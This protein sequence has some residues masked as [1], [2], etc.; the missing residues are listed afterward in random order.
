MA[1]LLVL[2][3]ST[4]YRAR[5]VIRAARRL[6]VDLVVATDHEQVL[7][8]QT[9]DATLTIPFNDPVSAWERVEELHG[10]RP[11]DAVVGLDDE[12]ILAAAALAQAL[13]VPANSPDAIAATRSKL[14]MRTLLAAAG[15]RSPEFRA[16]PLTDLAGAAAQQDFP[17]VL[18]PT[19]LSGSRGV[20]RADSVDEFV[21]AGRRIAA[22]LAEI[23]VYQG[24][25]DSHL[26]MVESYLEGTEVA[27]DGLLANGNFQPIAFFDK[28]D[29]LTGPYFEETLYVTPSRHPPATLAAVQEEIQLAVLAL[30]LEHG[31]VHAEL[32][33]HRGTPTL[34]EIAARPIGG[35]CPRVVPL[36]LGV[37]LED[38]ILG[39]ALGAP[40]P[41][42]R[43]QQ[44]AG[45]MMMP[46]PRPGTLAAIDGLETARAVVGVTSV[47]ISIGTG[48]R[49]VPL[50]EGNRYL[51]F[52]FAAGS[53]PEAVE[54]ALRDAHACITLEITDAD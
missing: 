6:D 5:D 32:R 21:A 29:P 2:L 30:G 17:C 11:L 22:I 31:P 48:Q 54:K 36:A 38:L 44:A 41:P 42:L 3:P 12:S 10:R 27:V 39:A 19:F 46:I 35:L 24:G 47:E 14:R 51:G 25:P 18:K 20:I 33:L 4:S 13:G 50:P 53:T 8:S 9:S 15:L 40:P 28:P 45:V 16:L 52:I 1:R 23:D 34:L 37:E 26:I 49:L 7:E 43:Q